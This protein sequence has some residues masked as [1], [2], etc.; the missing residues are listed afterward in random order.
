MI[1]FA[2]FPRNEKPQLHHVSCVEWEFLKNLL[3]P[4]IYPMFIL[5]RDVVPGRQQAGNLFLR[6]VS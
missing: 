3:V 1:Y 2:P 6:A 5:I 4:D